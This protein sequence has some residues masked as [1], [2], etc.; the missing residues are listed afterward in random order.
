MCHV[1]MK[2]IIASRLRHSY[3][4]QQEISVIFTG[5]YD[6]RTSRETTRKAKNGGT[7]LFFAW[8]HEMAESQ[9]K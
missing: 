5:E 3:V 4:V 2:F 8:N 9:R 1:I 6:S 7:V